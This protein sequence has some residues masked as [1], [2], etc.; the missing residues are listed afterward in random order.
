MELA[1]NNKYFTSPPIYCVATVY[2]VLDEEQGKLLVMDEVAMIAVENVTDANG[3]AYR[4]MESKPRPGDLILMYGG[5][6][7]DYDV[8]KFTS[9]MVM[10]IRPAEGIPMPE[11]Y[12]SHASKGLQYEYHGDHYTV[13]G[14]GGC[15]DS[16]IV[17]PSKINGLP[18]TAIGNKAFREQ[19]NIES[20]TLLSGTKEIGEYAFQYSSVKRV[21]LPEGFLHIRWYAFYYADLEE[22]QFPSSLESIGDFAFDNCG[23]LISVKLP[24]DLKDIGEFVFSKSGVRQLELPA[25]MTKIPNHAFSDMPNLEE[26]VLP[27]GLQSIGDGAFSFCNLKSVTIPAGVNQLGHSI[28]SF[29]YDLSQIRFLGNFPALHHNTFDGVWAQIQYPRGNATWHKSVMFD[30]C[31]DLTYEGYDSAYIGWL[32]LE[33]SS[34]GTYYILSGL[35]DPNLT[36]LI[37][38]YSYDEIPIRAIANGAFEGA[39]SLKR[40][41]LPGGLRTIGSSA[42]ANCGSLKEV[43]FTGAMPEVADNA[44]AGVSCKAIYPKADPSWTKEGRASYGGNLK[45]S[46]S[47]WSLEYAF[48][49]REKCYEVSGIGNF[50]GSYLQIPSTYD[51]YPVR[52]IQESVFAYN[53]QLETVIIGSSVKVIQTGA[54]SRCYNLKQVTLPEKLTKIEDSAFYRCGSLQQIHLPEKVK[55]IGHH[56]FEYCVSLETVTFSEKLESLSPYAFAYCTALREAILP[57]SLTDLADHA[58]YYCTSL[59]TVRLPGN[60]QTIEAYT[61]SHCE[62]LESIVLPDTVWA[63]WERAFEYCGI[64]SITLSSSL[65]EISVRAFSHCDK[66]QQITFPATLHHIFACA[67]EQCTALGTITFLGDMPYMPDGFDS[68]FENVVATVYYPAGNETWV[69]MHNYLGVLTWVPKEL[70]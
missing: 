51:G 55:E 14:I 30:Y 41:Q 18:V 4:D 15:K 52:Q 48:N 60:L 33:L 45:W 65:E 66:L 7:S 57:D 10:D 35:D 54:F 42:F 67:F 37:I 56:A 26:V 36:E 43:V 40:V 61:F 63:I 39:S 8:L 53:Q 28:F 16:Q 27:D 6:I 23:S 29:N 46:A 38:P 34:D 69:G 68:P 59:R 50:V 25:R 32:R 3:T 70:P 13:A 9:A 31:G 58:F 44:F 1:R 19:K 21:V 12:P 64:E 11:V 47:S 62:S 20:V 2:A 22:I 5:V 17:I 49:G 24:D